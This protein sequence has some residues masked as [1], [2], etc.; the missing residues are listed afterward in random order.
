MFDKTFVGLPSHAPVHHTTINQL[1][2]DTADAARLYGEIVKKAREEVKAEVV[3]MVDAFINAVVVRVESTTNLENCK[4]KVQ[5]WF[6][7]NGQM[8]DIEAEID[9]T[10]ENCRMAVYRAIGNEIA[11]QVIGRLERK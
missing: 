1:P 8:Y 6:K 9:P 4:R 7:L 3:S 2:L 5:V 10:L 11:A